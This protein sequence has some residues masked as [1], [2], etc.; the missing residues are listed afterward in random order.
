MAAE[1]N[2]KKRIVVV[3][4]VITDRD[5]AF[6]ARRSEEMSLPGM[7]EFPGGKIEKGETPRQALERELDEEL[8]IDVEIGDEVT[9]TEYE[10]D[11]GIVSLTTFYCH[12]GKGTPRV[13]EHA[14]IR[15]MPVAD[16]HELE[17]APADRPAVQL[18]Q[19]E[20]GR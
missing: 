3:G 15:W 20:F 10:Y 9:T 14:E 13:T 1:Q 17:W 6:C 16:L 5:R 18:V 4:A 11:F 19:R 2:N 7:W 8:L 12:L